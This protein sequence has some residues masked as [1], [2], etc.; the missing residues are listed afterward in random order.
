MEIRIPTPRIALRVTGDSIYTFMGSTNVICPSLSLL[1][2]PT[3]SNNLL[4]SEI[5]YKEHL[6]WIPMKES[7]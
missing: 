6:Y 5:Q 2:P 7:D 3:Y 4:L 1:F